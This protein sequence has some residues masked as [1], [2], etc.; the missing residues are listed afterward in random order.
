MRRGIRAAL[1]GVC[2]GALCGIALAA[3]GGIAARAETATVADE[4]A[5]PP[6]AQL[7]GEE[8]YARVVA[9][10]FDAYIQDLRLLSRDRGGNAQETRLT[11]TWQD[12]EA[13]RLPPPGTLSKTKVVYSYPFEIR[14]SAYLIIHKRDQLSDQFVYLPSRRRVRRVNL[15]G[16]NVFGTDFSF[17]DV[18]PRELEDAR[19]RRLPDAL[20]QGRPVFVVEA[21]PRPTANSEYSRFVIL[22]EKEHYVP[23]E[24][25]YWDEAG[26]AVKRLEADAASIR[27]F[28]GVWMPMRATMNHLLHDSQTALV[29]DEVVPNPDL[30]RGT[31]DVHRL[32]SH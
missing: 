12:W 23:L 10:R 30:P 9:N 8:I 3:G 19:Y 6:D 1:W 18:V 24:T 14:Y 22:V 20:A 13:A 21:I 26:V 28:D 5:F 25:R 17:E 4:D 2:A 15:R 11:M 31:F 32:E 16:E 7:T 29:V 27:E